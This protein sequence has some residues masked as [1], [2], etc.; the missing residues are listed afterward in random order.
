LKKRKTNSKQRP[1]NLAFISIH[2]YLISVLWSW[3][4]PSLTIQQEKK[5]KKA[6]VPECH[7]SIPLKDKKKKCNLV[8]EILT[9]FTKILHYLKDKKY[10]WNYST[11]KTKLT[12]HFKVFLLPHGVIHAKKVKRGPVALFFLL[13]KLR[14]LKNLEKSI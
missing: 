8:L 13:V 6:G 5:T 4:I 3:I 7:L 10:G 9:S 2:F 1:E 12:D 14:G 11:K